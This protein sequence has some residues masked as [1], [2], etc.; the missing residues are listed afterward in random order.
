MMQVEQEINP[1]VKLPEYSSRGIYKYSLGLTIPDRN[2]VLLYVASKLLGS[3]IDQTTLE[4]LAETLY[5]DASQSLLRPMAEVL[6]GMSLPDK[7]PVLSH[8]ALSYRL[9]EM[10]EQQ[11]NLLPV[12]PNDTPRG[13][14]DWAAGWG[15]A[16]PLRLELEVLR[17]AELVSDFKDAA[18]DD[19]LTFQV[20]ER[21][22]RYTDALGNTFRRNPLLDRHDV[23]ISVGRFNQEVFGRLIPKPSKLTFLSLVVRAI[24]ERL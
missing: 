16:R 1:V 3:R 24:T 20:T 14:V 23:L 4:S 7:D 6:S 10:E 5:Q 11:P 2:L 22:L 13:Y 8:V 21:G 15:H 9:D 18:R 17:S 19:M 12:G